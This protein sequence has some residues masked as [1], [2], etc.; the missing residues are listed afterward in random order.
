MTHLQVEQ[1]KLQVKSG[2]L[3]VLLYSECKFNLALNL[4]TT[5]FLCDFK[6]KI[7]FS[8]IMHNIMT[9]KLQLIMSRYSLAN[10]RSPY[11]KEKFK[12]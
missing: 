6:S 2:V 5:T 7:L 12:E 11:A 1:Q 10:H 9:M 3:W 8:V 4:V